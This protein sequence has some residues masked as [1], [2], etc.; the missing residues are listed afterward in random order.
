MNE[1]FRIIDKDGNGAIDASELRELLC[2]R[3]PNEVQEEGSGGRR[4]QHD[5]N[6]ILGFK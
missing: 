6:R 4:M 3:G 2:S 1:V 5:C